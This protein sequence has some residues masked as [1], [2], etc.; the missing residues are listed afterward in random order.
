MRVL[1]CVLLFM[2]TSSC[3]GQNKPAT[4]NH[5]VSRAVGDTVNALDKSIWYVFQDR[6]NNYWFGSNGQGVYRYDGRY[7]VQ[8]TRKHGL[9]NDQI[10]VIQED[11]H[12]NLY[13][14]TIGGVSKFNGH[15]FT[16]LKISGSD[17]ANA[18]WRLHPDDLWFAGAQDSGVVYRYEG[19]SLFRLKFPKTKAG[20]N[21]IAQYPRSKYPQMTFSPYDVYSIYKDRKG[22][23]WFGTNLGV[24]RYNGKT[25][26]W[27]SEKEL[28]ID[29]ISLHVRSTYEDKDGYFW[30]T[31]TMHRFDIYSEN[32]NG[33]ESFN[34]IKVNGI[35]NSKDHD[36]SYFMSSVE[37][38]N[39]DLWMVTYSK[40]V[41]RYDG[42][43][44]TH[45]QVKDGNEDAL[46]FSIYKDRMGDLWL[47]T[48]T[49]G[50]YKFNGKG[51]EQFRP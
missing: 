2:F 30:F 24:C 10:R 12:G 42:K 37:D 21:F 28:G 34:P 14:N 35:I 18:G 49:A 11:E 31:N 32:N 33:K 25:F 4:S 8:F 44:L 26:D 50:A 48:H 27:L 1:C 46:L 7:L 3:G 40:G 36:V 23:L 47:G 51:F 9:C 13:F 39:G 38:N 29:D 22:N 5:I 15:V 45:Y 6:K 41:W 43:E 20:E 16:T 17:D 19:A